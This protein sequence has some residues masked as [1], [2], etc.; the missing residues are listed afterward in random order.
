L[1]ILKTLIFCFSFD[2]HLRLQF[3]WFVICID[4]LPIFLCPTT[5]ALSAIRVI[6]IQ[7][8]SYS[9]LKALLSCI[10]EDGLF[11]WVVYKTARDLSSPAFFNSCGVSSGLLHCS[12]S[13]LTS[14]CSSV[15]QS[16]SA[17]LCLQSSF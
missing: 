11:L 10:Q 7:T 3:C 1:P 6:N 16:F 15:Y 13:R 2:F 5:C 12:L 9:F 17:I 4:P 8:L 14:L